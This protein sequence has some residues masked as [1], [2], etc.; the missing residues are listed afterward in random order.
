MEEER[1]ISTAKLAAFSREFPWLE[2]FVKAHHFT[3]SPHALVDLKVFRA[4]EDLL[5]RK[6]RSGDDFIVKRSWKDIKRMSWAEEN[7]YRDYL[8]RFN[9]AQE[10]IYLLGSDGKELARIGEIS[11]T[12][13][14]GIL[15]KRVVEDVRYDDDDNVDLALQRLGFRASEVRYVVSLEPVHSSDGHKL[16]QRVTIYKPPKKMGFKE[17]LDQRNIEAASTLAAEFANID[18]AA[19]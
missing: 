18:A 17:W 15:Q 14:K 16:G 2:G 9:L 1:L 11:F 7:E 4:D 13:T 6:P 5:T 10:F 19:P 12:R 3:P 8:L